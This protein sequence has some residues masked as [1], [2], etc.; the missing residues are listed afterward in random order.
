M[1][2]QL[3]KLHPGRRASST[4]RYK[5]KVIRSTQQHGRG[6]GRNGRA[7]AQVET[8]RP[9][10]DRD[11]REHAQGRLGRHEPL[12]HRAAARGEPRTLV[13]Q[14]IGRGL[15][16]PYGKR[17]GV[18]AV[19]GSPSSPTTGSRRSSTKLTERHRSF[20]SLCSKVQ[21]PGRERFSRCP[22]GSR[23]FWALDRLA[24]RAARLR[25]S[26]PCCQPSR[27]GMSSVPRSTSCSRW[28]RGSVRRQM[29]PARGHPR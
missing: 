27:R 25:H 7:A 1:P 9:D 19:D 16:L 23:P 24:T 8:R 26:R 15:R 20:V 29:L 18:A 4:G 5:D 17:T 11:P 2:T 12:H 3:L 28:R 21:R 13:E 22:H 10:R 14:S 6:E